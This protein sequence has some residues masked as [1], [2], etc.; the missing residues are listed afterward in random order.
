VFLLAACDED[1][2]LL[3]VLGSISA[4][5]PFGFGDASLAATSHD[6]GRNLMLFDVRT[7]Q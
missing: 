7:A 6:H 3:L 1:N 2:L 5:L 4:V